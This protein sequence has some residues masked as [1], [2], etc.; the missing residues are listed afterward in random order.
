VSSAYWRYTTLIPSYPNWYPS[1]RLSCIALDIIT[2]KLS[3]A[4]KNKKDDKGSLCLKPLHTPNSFVGLPFTRSD[5]RLD[6]RHSCIQ[7]NFSILHWTPFSPSHS[8]V[9]FNLPSRM[10]FENRLW[11][12]R[13]PFSSFWPHPLVHLHLIYH[14]PVGNRQKMQTDFMQ[15][16]F[17]SPL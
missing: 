12:T 7:S 6:W 8:Q 13:L 2:L 1:N 10:L 17:G 3:T 9:I 5:I 15:L 4:N 16:L 14:P 11:S